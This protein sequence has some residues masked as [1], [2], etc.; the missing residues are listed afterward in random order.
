[1]GL[2]EFFSKS[3]NYLTT[4]SI[5]DILDVLIVAGLIFG[6]IR[7][8]RRT[9]AIRL[10]RGIVLVLLALVISDLL[11]L[12]MV[13]SLMQRI[14]ELGLL[15]IVI[16][17]QPEIRRLL[18]RMGSGKFGY[19]F[20]AP[21]VPATM[22]SVINQTVLACTIMS[23][24]R[25]G[26]LIVFE[27]TSSLND[28]IATGTVVN[29]EVS[30]EL[31]RNIF[32]V[33][34]PLHDGAVIMRDGRLAAAGCMLPLSNNASLSSDLGMRHR[35]GIGMSEHSDAV[36]AIVSEETGSIS[37]AMDGMLK[38]HLTP[39][40]FG[41]ILR[42]ELMPDTESAP[43]RRGIPGMIDSLKGLKVKKNDK[44]ESK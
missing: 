8:I 21:G 11:N 15:A 18:E 42:A 41:K 12:Q 9:N 17:F 44:E 25:T 33:N 34:S 3:I 4:M 2:N 6:C 36:V 35:A 26:A 38:R 7:L 16:I 1:M 5:S 30:S 28:Q 13:R 40:T 37:V 31:L 29:A 32:F 22:E 14:V 24:S 23:D 27:R 39:D 20:G 19:F 43:K 10:A